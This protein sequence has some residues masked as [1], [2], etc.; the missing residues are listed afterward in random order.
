MNAQLI[1]EGMANME[2][3]RQMVALA[4]DASPTLKRR[5]E[6]FRKRMNDRQDRNLAL[7]MSDPDSKAY[8][9]Y[10]LTPSQFSVPVPTARA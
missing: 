7:I 1:G 2:R 6:R 9:D 3:M 5:G 8:R 4:E 10:I